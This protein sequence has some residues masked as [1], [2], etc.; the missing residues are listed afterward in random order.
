MLLFLPAAAF[1]LLF[2]IFR[3]KKM[4]WRS[5][6][7]AAAVFCGTAVVLITETLSL[8]RLL[9]PAPVAL[10]WLII[11][12]LCF[13]YFYTLRRRRQPISARAQSSEEGL[14][15]VTK[16]LLVACGII[17][18]FVAITAIVA[19]PSTWDGMDYHLPRVTMW[20]SNHSVRFYPTPDY[21]QLMFG[22]WAEFAM[23]HTYLLSAGDR[24]VNLVEFFCFLGS[25]IGVSLIAKMLGAG[26]RG[27][28]LAAVVCATIP[29][30][31]LEASGP[32][33]TYVVSFW[34]MAA[35]VFLMVWNEDQ[36]WL[37]A[38]CIGLA[39]GLAILSKGDTYIYLPFLVLACWW[40][41]SS[42]ARIRFM[43]RCAIFLLLI[44]ALNGP[45][46]FRAYGLTGS[47]LGLP[48][49]DGGPR[50]HWMVD[51]F[52][53]RGIAANTVRNLSVHIFT[54]VEPVNRRIDSVVRGAIQG[55]GVSPDDPQSVWPGYRFDI[56]HF[57][58]H[59]SHAGNPLHLLLLLVS[60]GL[61]L[62]K[63]KEGVQ[64]A[65]RWYTLGIV[66]AFLFFSAL[67]RWQP[68]A[69]RHHLPL[70]V[71]G[72]ALC[73]LVLEKYFP[74]RAGTAIAIVLILYALPFALL[75]R[76]RSLIP[77]SRVDDV[78]QPRSILYFSDSH[79]A[80]AQNYI[81]TA[82]AVKQLNCANIAIDSYSEVPAS[83][84]SYEPKSFFVYPLFAL[85]H[86]DGQKRT[87]WY[88]GVDNLTTRYQ[89]EQ[90]H[91]APCAVICLECANVPQKW[92]EYRAMAGRSE[93][94]DNI[95]VFGSATNTPNLGPN[96]KG[97]N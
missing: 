64:P 73:G 83:Q 23:M 31:I 49:P 70:F 88:T 7:L 26:Q 24:F 87:I 90:R 84:I 40:M 54:P 60:I 76:T 38:I 37:H 3:E 6:V 33:N 48:F 2:L 69:S 47:P 43:K 34:I 56:N 11:C 42:A 55:I 17:V 32:M 82:S 14:D 16:A 91:P 21:A 25:I 80:I 62:W 4:D 63:R 57:S 74:R 66:A 75:N 96:E 45:Q 67:L 71:L 97:S 15:R 86:A 1:L 5:A 28:A 13:F 27:Q 94:F 39:A 12:S 85:I 58:F 44:S 68:W 41:G 77:W 81:A 36:S 9:S 95:V 35:V 20:M 65:A 72:A 22:P 46:F 10:S 78:Y 52:S 50:L 93:V 89:T 92:A 61:V 53:L 51:S 29:E 79:E 30:G 19:P 59:E 8:P 18:L